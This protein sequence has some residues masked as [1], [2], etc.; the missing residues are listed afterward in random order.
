MEGWGLGPTD[1]KPDLVYTRI[2][3]YGQTG[4]MATL[5]GYASVAEAFGGFRCSETDYFAFIQS[6]ILCNI[7]CQIN[8]AFTCLNLIYCCY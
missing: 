2:S 8:A 7:S 6:S 4:P 5:P 3:G 1:L